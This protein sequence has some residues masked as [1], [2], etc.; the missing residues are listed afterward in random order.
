M[1][2][3]LSVVHSVGAGELFDWSPLC[4]HRKRRSGAHPT[5]RAEC[6]RE[7]EGQEVDNK[8]EAPGRA[9]RLVPLADALATGADEDSSGKF[10]WLFCPGKPEKITQILKKI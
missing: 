3:S 1:T 7:A 9:S 4:R 5:D 8:P 10:A 2:D 6:A